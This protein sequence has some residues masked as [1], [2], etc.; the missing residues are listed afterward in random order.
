MEGARMGGRALIIEARLSAL[1]RDNTHGTVFSRRHLTDLLTSIRAYSLAAALVLL[2][3]RHPVVAKR[4]PRRASA[5]GWGSHGRGC[6]LWTPS[7]TKHSHPCGP[8]LWKRSPACVAVRWVRSDSIE[9]NFD[10]ANC[11]SAIEREGSKPWW[12]GTQQA[13]NRLSS[14]TVLMMTGDIQGGSTDSDNF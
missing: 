12:S 2:P 11:S 10:R 13:C 3:A 4:R 5:V 14:E 7:S 1:M 9:W 6:L 8:E